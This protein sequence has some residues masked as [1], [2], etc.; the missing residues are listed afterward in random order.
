M[1]GWQSSRTAVIGIASVVFVVGC[2]LP[3]GD[4][5]AAPVGSTAASY[6][7]IWLD[8]RQRGLLYNTALLGTRAAILA[9]AIG[10]PLGLALARMALPRKALLRLALAAPVLLPPYVVG[11]SWIY[12]GSSRGL[13]ASCA[14]IAA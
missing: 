10:A 7:A 2:M 11:L 13:V 14:Q 8:A 3:V 12:L 5:L 1:W 6:G 9:T 4:L